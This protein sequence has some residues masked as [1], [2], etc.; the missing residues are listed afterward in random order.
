MLCTCSCIS[1]KKYEN[2]EAE[3]E[4]LKQEHSQL[5][6]KYNS[7]AT[8]YEQMYYDY[9]SSEELRN[10]VD[11]TKKRVKQLKMDVLIYADENILELDNDIYRIEQA[12]DGWE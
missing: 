9:T 11:N 5:V 10:I 12:L 7:M 4:R 2:L 8:V 1:P 6:E 3:Y